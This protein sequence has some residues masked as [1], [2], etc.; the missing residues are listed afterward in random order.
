MTP[1]GGARLYTGNPGDAG[2]V[3]VVDITGTGI[4]GDD[5]ADASGTIP[6]GG[7]F[8]AVDLYTGPS[9]WIYAQIDP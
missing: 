4:A 3:F 2:S 9:T 7:A 5:G 1:G 6:E 8:G